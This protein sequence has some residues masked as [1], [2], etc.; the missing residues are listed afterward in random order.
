[1][2]TENKYVRK[3]I[4]IKEYIDN[5]IYYTIYRKLDY[6]L[7]AYCDT[8]KEAIQYAKENNIKITK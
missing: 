2:K 4:I 5:E 7:I 8:K 6:E 1:M 3:A